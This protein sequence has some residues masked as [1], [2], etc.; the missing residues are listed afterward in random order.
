MIR[1]STY[2]A[3]ALCF[4]AIGLAACGTSLQQ[5]EETETVVRLDHP[6]F[7][8]APSDYR[9][10]RD[11]FTGQAGHS[12][13]YKVEDGMAHLVVLVAG[14]R[15][16]IEKIE[17]D[18]DINKWCENTFFKSSD[19]ENSTPIS[20][21]S[22]HGSGTVDT[23]YGQF[24]YRKFFNADRDCACFIH[25]WGSRGGTYYQGNAR[26]LVGYACNNSGKLASTEVEKLIKAINLTKR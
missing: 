15:E 20:L 16:Y 4:L 25:G 13:A 24:R 19:A 17:D 23:T 5:I 26:L 18:Q 8:D 6:R 3:L 12:A 1:K 21:P 22:W 7:A 10:F 14:N 11:G 9:I 2:H